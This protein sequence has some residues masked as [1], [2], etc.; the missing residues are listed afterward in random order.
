M[1]TTLIF[2]GQR[3]SDE[4]RKLLGIIGFLLAVKVFQEITP[5]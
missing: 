4:C 5:A 2:V 1:G 3:V